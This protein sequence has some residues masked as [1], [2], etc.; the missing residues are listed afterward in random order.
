MK[1]ISRQ[2]V[3]TLIRKSLVFSEH[4]LVLLPGKGF[5]L[6]SLEQITFDFF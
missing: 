4:C 3:F 1:K 5:S 6:N 2:G